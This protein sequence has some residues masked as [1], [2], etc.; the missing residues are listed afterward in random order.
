KGELDMTD[1]V[2]AFTP[3]TAEELAAIEGATLQED[4]QI[5]L[6][7]IQMNNTKPP[8]DDINVRKAI[9]YAFDY[10]AILEDVFGGGELAQG[11][12]PNLMPGH[13]EDVIQYRQDLEKAEFFLNRLV[14]ATTRSLL[15]P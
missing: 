8:L 7:A 4:P 9:S 14:C 5:R 12:V 3:A 10:D 15:W 2:L 1:D 11:P 13:A 6:A